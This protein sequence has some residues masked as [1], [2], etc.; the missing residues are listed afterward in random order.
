MDDS[1]GTCQRVASWETSRYGG[2]CLAAFRRTT[3]QFSCHFS[4]VRFP[5]TS[6]KL[7][8]TR[9]NEQFF[10][11][12]ILNFVK[13][14]PKKFTYRRRTRLSS[15]GFAFFR[16][17]G[18]ISVISNSE[19]NKTKKSVCFPFSQGHQV[20]ILRGFQFSIQLLHGDLSFFF[21]AA[22]KTLI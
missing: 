18:L 8:F 13:C 20:G 3:N 7:T 21:V 5:R 1:D 12:S 16:D 2:R 14:P 4:N 6:R 9:K 22:P 15:W 17:N 10:S 19:A 11:Q